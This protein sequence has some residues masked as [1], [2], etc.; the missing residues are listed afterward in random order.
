MAVELSALVIS[1]L[2]VLPS[3][4]SMW[5]NLI[6]RQIITGLTT[7]YTKHCRLQFDEYTQVQESHGNTTQERTTGVISLRPTGNTQGA[8][9]FM[10]LTTGRI[11]NHQSF[12]PLPL[13][14]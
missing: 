2:N 6:P 9:F 7:D 3:S 10:S 8:Y 12:N 11:L 5:G 1:W 13:P 4:P 14:Q